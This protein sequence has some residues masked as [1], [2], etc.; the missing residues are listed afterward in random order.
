MN[1]VKFWEAR[2]ALDY[3]KWEHFTKVIDKAN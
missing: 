3:N 2:I 1:L